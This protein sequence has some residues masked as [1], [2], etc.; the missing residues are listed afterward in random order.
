MMKIGIFAVLALAMVLFGTAGPTQAQGVPAS[1][2][3]PYQ[4]HVA[5]IEAENYQT[6][7][8]EARAAF[9]AG[10][11]ADIDPA[12]LS[13]LARNI[14]ETSVLLEDWRNARRWYREAA[15]IAERAELYAQML[16]T[17][18]AAVEAVIEAEDLNSAY[19]FSRGAASA[20]EALE[21]SGQDIE[22]AD[23]ARGYQANGAAAKLAFARARGRSARQYAEAGLQIVEDAEAQPGVLYADLARILGIMATFDGDREAAWHYLRVASALRERLTPDAEGM[24]E[25]SAWLSY[26]G[27]LVDVERRQAID[28]ELRARGILPEDP[29]CEEAWCAGRTQPGETC[30]NGDFTDASPDG[31]REHPRYPGRAAWAGAGGFA[32]VDFDIGPDGRTR[33]VEVVASA[34]DDVFDARSRRAVERW[35]YIPAVCDGQSVSQIG[36]VTFFAFQMAD[37]EPDDPEA[38]RLRRQ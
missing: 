25:L 38:W 23:I 12:T 15:Q 22:P 5:A 13:I 8:S 16:E 30:P 14:A 17:L 31:E 9:E 1:V 10:D 28:D 21:E 24:R 18:H 37:T 3:E 20:F 19:R 2:L 32:L 36:V 35:R 34:P 6:A 4:R 29:E 27:L 7:L 26:A 11:A 33:N